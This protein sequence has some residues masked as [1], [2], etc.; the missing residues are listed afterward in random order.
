[1]VG[2]LWRR[3][4]ANPWS[5]ATEVAKMR[6]LRVVRASRLPHSRMLWCRTRV[7]ARAVA[8]TAGTEI[9]SARTITVRPIWTLTAGQGRLVCDTAATSCFISSLFEEFIIDVSGAKCRNWPRACKITDTEQ[10]NR[11]RCKRNF[12]SKC[13]TQALK[14]RF[15][16]AVAEL[17]DK[18]SGGGGQ[19][20]WR[21]AEFILE[22]LTWRAFGGGGGIRR[23]RGLISCLSTRH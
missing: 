7:Q 6:P 20:W 18:F 19:I 17:G 15:F 22:A 21:H 14:S 1:M 12:N 8:S 5:D 4:R 2:L 10:T 23:R 3:S 11:S 13:Q 9:V 16:A